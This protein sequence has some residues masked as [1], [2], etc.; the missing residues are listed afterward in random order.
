MTACFCICIITVV[1]DFVGKVRGDIVPTTLNILRNMSC[2]EWQD[3][4]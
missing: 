2:E 4:I 1:I 3:S